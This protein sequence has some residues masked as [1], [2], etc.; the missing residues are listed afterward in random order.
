MGEGL[1]EGRKRGKE[2]LE[3]GGSLHGQNK[4]TKLFVIF[5]IPL[6]T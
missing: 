4:N 3:S 2:R 1:E 5:E 6:P